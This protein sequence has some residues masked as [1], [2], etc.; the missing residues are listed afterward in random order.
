[1]IHL[2]SQ[3]E[4]SLMRES[5]YIVSDVHRL[6]ASHVK[7]GVTL[8]ELDTMAEDF[9]R[10]A[11]GRPAFKGYQSGSRTVP[12]FPATLCISLDDEVV[13]GIPDGRVLREGQVV[14]IDVGVE[15]NGYYGDA[16][17]TLPVGKINP[18]DERLLSVTK[19]SFFR[20]I[21]QAVPGNH[22]G[23]ISA[24][25]QQYVEENGF[26]V[27]RDLVGHGIGTHLHEE[28]SVPNFGKAGTGPELHSGMT[29][30]IEPMVNY[31]GHRVRVASNGWTILTR[32]AS[33]SAHFEHTVHISERGPEL[34]TDHFQRDHGETR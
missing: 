5:C 23:D 10:S 20:G 19:E 18:E 6:L 27:V 7:P 15:K 30:A 17:V 31:G 1:M 14:S 21:D 25:V 2:K 24:A 3:K 9:I 32:D 11:G 33:T 4:I 13:H 34:L 12:P 29:L 16:A 28:P 26:S 8:L 22:L